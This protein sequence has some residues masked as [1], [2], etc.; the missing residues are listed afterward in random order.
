MHNCVKL[1]GLSVPFT[2]ILDGAQGLVKN[3]QRLRLVAREDYVGGESVVTADG[4]VPM[5]VIT[6]RA[7]GSN[8]C[9]VYAPMATAGATANS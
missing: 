7:D 4:F 6:D 9:H 1:K 2:E 3:A 5:A 8:D